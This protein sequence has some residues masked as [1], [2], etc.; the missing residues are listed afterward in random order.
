ML[1]IKGLVVE[2][3]GLLYTIGMFGFY[4]LWGN[5]PVT[6]IWLLG[7]H[8]FGKTAQLNS[9]ETPGFC[10]ILLVPRFSGSLC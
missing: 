10:F 8:K 7:R 3:E 2:R 6:H 9:G 5:S 1:V 4:R